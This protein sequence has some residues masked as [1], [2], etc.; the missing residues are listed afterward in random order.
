MLQLAPAPASVDKIA[1]DSG[2]EHHDSRNEFVSLPCQGEDPEL[3]F[4][5]QAAKLEKAKALC[6][7][8][9]LQSA[10]LNAAL[11]RSEPWGVWGGQIFE[12]GSIIGMKR[13]RGR[14]RKVDS[15]S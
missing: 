1:P 2:G 14:P 8:C 11:E 4:A 7:A 13:G 5:E 6:G 3:W 10:C 15:I 12:R 9:P